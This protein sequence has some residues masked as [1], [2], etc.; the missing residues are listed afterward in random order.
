MH[1]PNPLKGLASMANRIFVTAAVQPDPEFIIDPN[2]LEVV[3][4]GYDLSGYG[5]PK[6][7]IVNTKN[8]K[9]A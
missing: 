8:T 6:P 9:G 3:P 5:A 1:L 2:Q 4:D 7:A